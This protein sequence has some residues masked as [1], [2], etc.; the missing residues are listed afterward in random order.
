MIK[1]VHKS[2]QLNEEMK[3]VALVRDLIFFQGMHPGFDSRLHSYLQSFGRE[4]HVSYQKQY[5]PLMIL[6]MLLLLSGLVFLLFKLGC[7][8]CLVRFLPC[9]HQL[10]EA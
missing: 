2:D 10:L 8:I 5:T 7:H 9:T 6:D 1:N 4:S 3:V